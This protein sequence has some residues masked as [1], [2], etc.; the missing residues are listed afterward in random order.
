[1]NTRIQRGFSI[2]ELMVAMA[3]SLIL[4]AGVLAVLY[5]SKVTYAE[6][7]RLARV[8][9]NARVATEMILRDMR[10]GG[11]RGCG[12]PLASGDLENLLVDPTALT[13]NFTEP[14]RG[15][16][17]SEGADASA[18]A[19]FGGDELEIG[20]SVVVRSVRSGIPSFRLNTS[21]ADGESL[22]SIDKPAGVTIE[23]GTPL[24][25]SNC[26]RGSVFTSSS[27]IGADVVVDVQHTTDATGGLVNATSDL[28]TYLL[29]SQISPLSTIAYYVKQNPAGTGPALWRMVDDDLPAE[30]IIDGVERLE[31]LYG[32]D[33]DGDERAD[34]YIEADD[35]TNWNNITSASVSVMVRSADEYGSDKNNRS[36]DMLGTLVEPD[37]D[38][39]L[40]TVFTTTASLRNRTP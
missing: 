9:E 15:F 13:H 4:L 31:I 16:E 20:D 25:I 30:P 37:A 3:L 38:R 36:F 10:S 6:N 17:G 26:E 23:A 35:V 5:S 12:R 7:E 34:A 40:R 39:Y 19:A 18:V 32:E 28:G 29:G 33:T 27:G 14:M 22:L 21:M 11:F 2:V 1:M 24:L 8:Q